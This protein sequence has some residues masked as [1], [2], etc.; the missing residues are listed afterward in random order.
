MRDLIER[1][2]LID[3]KDANAIIKDISG[4]VDFFS[5]DEDKRDFISAHE[6]ETAIAGEDRVSYGDWQT[7]RQLAEKVCERHIR[8]YGYPD[9]MIEPTCGLGSFVMSALDKFPDLTEIHAVEIN[10]RYVSELKFNLLRN[11]LLSP[12]QNYPDIYIHNADFFRFD[13]SPII[14]KARSNNWSLAIIGNPPWVTNSSQGRNNSLNLPL[15]QNSFGLKGIEAITGKSNFDIS[16]YI[17]LQLLRMSQQNKGGISFLL[18]N[19]VIRNILNKQ[20]NAPLNIG[21]ITQESIDAS[22]EFNVSVDASCFCARFDSEPAM[23]CQITDFYS[24]RYIRKYGWVADSFVADADIY[25]RFAPYDSTSTYEW[26]SGIKH[27]CASVLELTLDDG[28]FHNGYGERVDIE[29]DLIFPLL[30][31]SDIKRHHDSQCRKYIIVTQR[32]VGEDTSALKYTHPRAYAYLTYH[33][34]DFE[35]RKSSIYKGKDVFSI[36]GIGAYSFKPFKI[37]VSA[38]YKDIDFRLVAQYEGKPIMVDD[39][40]YQLDF[41]DIG[42]ANAVYAAVQSEEIQS[43]LGSLVFKDAKRVITKGILARLNL[44]RLCLDKGISLKSRLNKSE[45]IMP[46]SLFG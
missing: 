16:E 44:E 27:D 29:D 41:D 12:R 11:T 26:R 45:K 28:V 36:F 17:T 14:R 35:R 5:S 22:A 8:K 43:L 6:V 10:S 19:S 40:C 25:Q 1:L 23:V 39:T 37:V 38:L 46:P 15:K 9:I 42:E 31:S 21:D 7:P 18:K 30:K 33:I 13:F 24:G 4:I 32:R 34:D 3:Y 20:K 2:R